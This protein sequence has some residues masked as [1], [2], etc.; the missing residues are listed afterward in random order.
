MVILV[1][2]A[3]SAIIGV[4]GIAF[5]LYQ[6]R[7]TLRGHLVF[8][9]HKAISPHTDLVEVFDHL[10]ITFENKPVTSDTLFVKGCIVNTGRE[11]VPEEDLKSPVTLT[12]PASHGWT[13]FVITN[14]AE[15]IEPTYSHDSERVVALSWKLL[16]VDESIEFQAVVDKAADE[17]D[18]TES[19]EA[20]DVDILDLIDVKY[21]IPNFGPVRVLKAPEAKVKDLIRLTTTF[22]VVMCLYAMALWIVVGVFGYRSVVRFEIENPAGEVLQGS[23]SAASDSSLTIATEEGKQRVSI[24]E[25][26]DQWSMRHPV[27]VRDMASYWSLFGGASLTTLLALL[28]GGLTWLIW[29]KHR[30]VRSWVF[31]SSGG[32]TRQREREHPSSHGG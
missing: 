29:R 22:F 8:V 17:P 4:L 26:T 30:R 7:R 12:L 3:T 31:P 15:G 23:L 9:K 21:R 6:G 24:E 2:T 18:G 28:L 14:V 11:D 16:R 20:D 19:T 25:F 10:E 5:T 13:E 1:I 27:I 32:G